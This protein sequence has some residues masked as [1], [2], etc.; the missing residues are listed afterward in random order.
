MLRYAVAMGCVLVAGNA[1]TAGE[2]PL[3]QPAPAWVEPSEPSIGDS[4]LAL[5]LLDVQYRV[6]NGKMWMYRDMATYAGSTEILSNLATVALPWLPDKGDLFIHR[7]EIERGSEKI[8]LLAEGKRF[9][10]L[11]R[12]LG[13]EQRILDGTL[14]ASLPIEG[15]QVGDILRVTTS[16]TITDPALAGRVQ[17]Q[18]IV[19]AAPVQ[20]G[21]GRIVMSWPEDVTLKW[22]LHATGATPS[23]T[24]K[25]GFQRL[26]I[27]FPLSKQTEMPEDAP[28]RFLAPTLVDASTFADWPDVSAT[29]AKLYATDGLIA[30]G[31]P[32]AAEVAK[33]AGAETDPLRRTQRALEL[34]Q[35]KVRYLLV[36]MNGGNYVPQT[37]AKT[38]EV[39]YG[40]CKAKTLLLLTILRELGVD[41][42]AVL[43]D[44]RNGD[45]V[46]SRQPAALA[47][48]HILV[49]AKISDQRYWLDGT[50]SG[51]RFED[52]GDVPDLGHVLPVRAAG[53]ALERVFARAP[54]RPLAVTTIDFDESAS[55]DLPTVARAA[56]TLRG[57]YAAYVK[58]AADQVDDAGKRQLALA[59]MTEALGEGLYTDLNIR[60]D[61]ASSQLTITGTGLLTTPWRLRE[62]RRTRFPDRLLT[63]LELNADRSKADW[64]SIPVVPYAANTLEQR[65]S[66]K[67]PDGGRDYVIEGDRAGDFELTGVRLTRQVG[68]NAGVLTV[69]ERAEFAKVEIAPANLP[70]AQNQLAIAQNRQIRVI[71]PQNATRRW[72]SERVIGSAQHKAIEAVFAGA[73]KDDPKVVEIF[74]SRARMR[75]GILDYAGALADLTSAIALEAQP[76]FYR[77]R[78]H[79]NYYLGRTE[80]AL[81][82]AKTAL[83]LDQSKF[84]AVD[85]RA[86]MLIRASDVQTAHALV[87][88][89]IARGGEAGK[90]YLGLK[91]QLMGMQ[92]DAA[93]AVKLI[94][95]L[96]ADRPNNPQFLTLRCQLRANGN[97]QLDA[98]L[99]D[100][101]KAIELGGE[102]DV[103]YTARALAYFR[104]GRSEDALTDLNAAVEVSRDSGAVRFLRALV[105]SALGRKADA[106]SERALALRLSPQVAVEYKRYGL[107]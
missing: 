47:F 63:S 92:G 88:E 107:G 17:I 59:A 22:K 44:T 15:L 31:S 32:L 41:A 6:E 4:K 67:L 11:R 96:I 103:S 91:A 53:S 54:K 62:R 64:A 78:S 33:I 24:R 84:D 50:I 45:W 75:A 8:D 51:S 58:M 19:P 29:F 73:I 37:P 49:R 20:I 2:T 48:D 40:D 100:C 18:D 38:W 77:R 81:A 39:R 21:L 9:Q 34:V 66:I 69:S 28:G 95:G 46:A 52:I 30:P 106:A 7:L 65:T 23:L 98:G 99:Q 76:D 10:V 105:L 26:Q 25:A 61:D 90:L 13:L 55:A 60:F 68:L 104:L 56:L 89:R 14:T 70:A 83:E 3:Y 102:T 71:A 43:V 57:A 27:D 97:I 35:D 85:W 87:D 94:E 74:D 79:I 42:E 16:T 80:A 5:R 72:D 1:A 86:T 93:G 12:E 101:T 36:A 82:D